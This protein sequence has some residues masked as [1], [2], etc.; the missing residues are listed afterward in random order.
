MYLSTQSFVVCLNDYWL[1]Q[2]IH[3]RV[4]VS[5]SHISLRYTQCS[6]LD[7]VCFFMIVC[8]IAFT[9]I[10]RAVR[11]TPFSALIQHTRT[12]ASLL[13]CITKPLLEERV[14]L[15]SLLLAYHARIRPIQTG[16]LIH[17]WVS[18]W[19]CHPSHLRSSPTL[20]RQQLLSPHYYDNQSGRLVEHLYL[21]HLKHLTYEDEVVDWSV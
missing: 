14:L 17:W 6:V 3:C 8:S 2:H 20:T 19:G 5:S 15:S 21:R 4:C 16:T 12:F 13:V 9:D 7:A 1:L 18:Y 11:S 10:R